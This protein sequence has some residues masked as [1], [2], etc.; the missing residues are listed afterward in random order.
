MRAP[1]LLIAG[2]L[3]LACEAK[4]PPT[5]SAPVTTTAPAAEDPGLPPGISG[6]PAAI[7]RGAGLSSRLQEPLCIRGEGRGK[8]KLEFTNPNSNGERLSYILYVE[9][10]STE[11]EE[12]LH[13]QLQVVADRGL[14][15]T[16]PAWVE[17][18]RY[19][20]YRLTV[21]GWALHKTFGGNRLC[22]MTGATK[23]RHIT[24]YQQLPDQGSGLLVYRV[25][26]E[27]GP[28]YL[29]WFSAEVRSVFPNYRERDP[30]LAEALLLRG[31]AGYYH[32]PCGCVQAAPTAADT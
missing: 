21:K 23:V 8:A 9:P 11:G 22:F 7:G 29:D 31:P 6:W 5:P 15:E 27:Y 30:K 18:E 13:K 32:A 25:N 12:R 2:A 24:D 28:D 20:G 19:E 16:L 26:Y 4:S 14:L 1:L 3:L 17:N 10:G